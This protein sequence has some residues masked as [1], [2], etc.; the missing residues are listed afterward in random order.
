MSTL[1]SCAIEFDL[2]H[3]SFKKLTI[4]ELEAIDLQQSDKLY[5][6]HSNLNQLDV[7]QKLI[8]KC[9]LPEDMVKLCE[10]VDIIPMARDTD[11]SLTIQ[12]Q[13]LIST[14]LTR[15]GA[16]SFG[17]LIIHLTDKFCFTA[18]AD[19]T[20]VLLEFIESSQKS[21]RYAKTPCFMIFLILDN[22]INDYAKMLLNFDVISDQMDLRVRKTHKNIYNEVI[23]VKQHLMKIKRSLIGL[24]EILL[25]ISDRKISVV[26]KECRL[27]LFK[28]ANHTHLVV[29]EVDSVRDILNSLLDQIENMMMQ[30]LNQSMRILTSLSMIFLPLTLIA[31]IYGMNFHWIPEL[32]WQYGYFYA[33][34]LMV[35]CAGVILFIFKKMKWF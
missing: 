19:P 31:G 30:T 23:R 25:R 33:L 20:P 35:I 21:L 14:D 5:W 2:M 22:I 10:Q 12:I 9:Y 26:S 3:R 15:R 1:D 8:K 6:I 7:H 17:N 11:E 32:A 34:S 4:D 16:V 24:R 29:H 18:T 13:C 27:S 28:L